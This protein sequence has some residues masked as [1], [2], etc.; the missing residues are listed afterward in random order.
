M[1][2]AIYYCATRQLITMDD[3]LMTTPFQRLADP[4]SISNVLGS[5]RIKGIVCN[6]Y[7][8]LDKQ[9]FCQ[10]LACKV[11][12]TRITLLLDETRL[13]ILPFRC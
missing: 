10:R 4:R 1:V 3:G 9:P 5:V 2:G 8:H 7:G 11:L 13:S 12:E 6:A